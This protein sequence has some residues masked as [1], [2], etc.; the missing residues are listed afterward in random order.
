MITYGKV[1]LWLWKSLETQG[2]FFS[3]HLATLYYR[4]CFRFAGRHFVIIFIIIIITVITVI[5]FVIHISSVAYGL[6][7]S[8]YNIIKMSV[9]LGVGV[10]L[11]AII[12]G[13]VNH[14]N[15]VDCL[16]HKICR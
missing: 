13:F 11:K 2:I 1:T 4:W 9:T 16:L 12:S 3:Y 14:C 8:V 6:E 15:V 7:I 5:V 10:S